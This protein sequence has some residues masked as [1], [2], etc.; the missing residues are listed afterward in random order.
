M[1]I[2]TDKQSDVLQLL[3]KQKSEHELGKCIK[4]SMTATDIGLAM[5]K[6]YKQASS[7]VTAPL[8]KLI[9]LGMVIQLDDR[10]Y[11]VDEKTFSELA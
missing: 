3:I 10:S 4:G 5:G 1:T 2:L 6:E 8:K 7:H 9:S 11:Q